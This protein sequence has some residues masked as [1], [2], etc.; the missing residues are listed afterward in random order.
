MFTPPQI[1][2]TIRTK[3]FTAQFAGIDSNVEFCQFW[4]RIICSKHSGTTLQL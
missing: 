1:E 4:S 3:T 2:T